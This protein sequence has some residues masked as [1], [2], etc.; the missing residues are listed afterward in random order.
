MVDY[1]Y[2][3][4]FHTGSVEK[5]LHIRCGG[6]TL[7]N[8][9][10]EC[11]TMVLT[12]TI[13]DKEELCFGCCSS[14]QFQITALNYG[15]SLAG[16]E[17]SVWLDLAGADQS[18]PLGKYTVSTD[19]ESSDGQYR[20]IIAYDALSSVFKAN[21]ADWYNGLTFPTTLRAFRDAFFSYLGI[22]QE[23]IALVNDDMLVEKTIEPSEISGKDVLY[24]ICEI[25]GCFGQINHHGNFQYVILQENMPGLY[26]A[27]DLYPADDLYPREK[28]YT[29]IDQ[30]EYFTCTYEKTVSQRIT[31]LRIRQEEHDI[32]ITVGDGAN[33]YVVEDNFLVYG[34][35]TEELTAIAN[36][37][38]GVIS[39][40]SYQPYTLEAVGDPCIEPGDCI[41]IPID[42]GE[43]VSYVLKRVLKGIQMLD[44]T[45]SAAGKEYHS[46][47]ANHP[48]K[49]IKQLK[50][51]VNKIEHT[52]EMTRLEISDLEKGM[53]SR[54]TQTAEQIST[55]VT[56]AQAAEQNLAGS[57]SS[58]NTTMLSR[59]TQTAEQI[60]TEV[61]RAQAA[62]QDLAGSISSV[63]TTMLSR[64][65]QTAE[66]ISTEVTRAQAA[67]QN[68]AGSISS[69]SAT[70]S[71]RFT[72]TADQIAAEV[73]R[74]KGQEVE[75][76]AALSIQANQ[77]SLK[78]AKGDVS[79]QLSVESGKIHITSDRFSWDSTY[80]SLSGDGKLTAKEVNLQGK[81]AATSGEIG[82]FVIGKT[83]IYNGKASLDGYESGVYLGTDGI[84]IGK[85]DSK[86]AV[87]LSR[88]GE[89]EIN[90]RGSLRLGMEGLGME[91]DEKGI[92]FWNST[93]KNTYITKDKI[94]IWN[95]YIDQN[96]VHCARSGISFYTDI[97]G[98]EITLHGSVSSGYLKITGAATTWA[99]NASSYY[100][101]DNYSNN[102]MAI[103]TGVVN[104]CS[105][106]VHI[107]G[108]A[109]RLYF[110]G[111][112][113]GSTKKTVAKVT[114]PRE[115]NTAT[116]ATTLN[117][118]ID[119]LK[120]YNLIG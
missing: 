43:V 51:K 63:S 65:T 30:G 83:A 34:K 50:G 11:D 80:S 14:S 54:F 17:I 98:D 116:I 6:D 115:A 103:R 36:N 24:S 107:G 3:D 86:P 13:C 102:L 100:L 28:N 40:A 106:N 87:K 114:S 113:V 59:F 78:V 110:F 70:M 118:L 117:N 5:Q 26:P 79:S 27:E 74:A 44:D 39:Q 2:R 69:V 111:E 31:K 35:G 9:D 1:E 92:S 67:E 119:A 89:I 109:S 81:I 52:I 45:Y 120:A 105:G 57:I 49:S 20:N 73:T 95:T 16:Q 56:R 7:D 68:L 32:G 38:L 22:A 41:R 82:G 75:L 62:E 10:L 58:V 66:Q 19:Q 15:N 85:S 97:C 42:G 4:L 96:T 37:L 72:Q 21:M 29:T 46:N 25:N 55:E 93:T 48:A 23:S 84:S 77:I 91:L 71:S 64:F 99:E 53:S 33:S 61:T 108:S 12:Q 8:E 101:K 90:S 60:S 18:F 88:D 94:S 76:A 47:D 104:I 112:M